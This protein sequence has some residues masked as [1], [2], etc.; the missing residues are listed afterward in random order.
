MKKRVIGTA[1]KYPFGGAVIWL[2]G[3][4]GAPFPLL[5][6]KPGP[7]SALIA[8]E[9]EPVPED[10]YYVRVACFEGP[11]RV[12]D[13]ETRTDD[14]REWIGEAGDL[15]EGYRAGQKQVRFIIW[16]GWYA[17]WEASQMTDLITDDEPDFPDDYEATFYD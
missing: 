1:V 11:V 2:T 15:V 4:Q 10:R 12:Y 17:N 6:W 16:P 9:G 3:L 7:V 8:E 14:W 5:L 13:P